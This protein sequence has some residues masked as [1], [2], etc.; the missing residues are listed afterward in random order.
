[1]SRLT[2]A[3]SAA[4]LVL[5]V[6]LAACGGGSG[7]ATSPGAN[8]QEI[9]AKSASRF[10]SVKTFHYR[11]EHENGYIPVDLGALSL[12]LTSAEGDE[13]VPSRITA[14]VQGKLG[15][16]NVHVNVIGIDDKTWITNP[17]TRSWQSAPGTA[18]IQDLVDPVGLVKALASSLQQA[19]V[20]GMETVDGVQAYRISG[21]L[22]S[23]A[24]TKSLAFAEGGRTL[25]VEAWI[26]KD[27]S[28]PRK[29]RLKG[30]L[31][32]DDKADTVRQIS[33]SK[34]DAPVTIQPP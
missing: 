23:D 33:L 10:S 16:T 28:L 1:M 13:A 32:A 18:S 31:I 7:G 9:L 24:L 21:T 11:L 4:T 8:A 5:A 3:A 2:R 29:A 22:S 26:G 6:L 34:F 15:P 19:K 12:H 14:D 30:A 20:D 27:D 17:F 25:N